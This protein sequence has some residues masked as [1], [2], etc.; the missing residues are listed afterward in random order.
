VRGK[1]RARQEASYQRVAIGGFDVLV[2]RSGRG[3]DALLSRESHPADVWLHA[4]GVPGGHVLIRTAGRDVP[5]AV[6]RQ[7]AALAAGQSQARTAPLV[8]V[9]YT[10][11][12]NVARIKGAPPGL[13][14]Y[15]GERTLHV[16]P[17]GS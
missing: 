5:D 7:A 3:N 1:A 17:S 16:A 2:G 8:A 9:D 15:R 6:L 14:T 13:V 10:L 12:R 4:R 11:R